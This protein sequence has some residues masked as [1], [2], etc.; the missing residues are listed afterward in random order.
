LFDIFLIES[1]HLLMIFKDRQ[2]AG[3]RLSEALVEFKNNKQTLVL[4]LPRGGVPVAFE[5]AKAL[6]LPL[7]I[8]IVRKLG[9]PGQEELAMG[10]I[11]S[12][13]GVFLNEE[14]SQHVS[15][16]AIDFEIERQ[17]RKIR[18]RL[19]L[20]GSRPLNLK[21]HSVILVDDGLATGASMMVAINTV[22]RL[23]VES[24]LVAVPV[25]PSDTVER[26]RNQVN[27]IIVL[28]TPEN[29]AGVGQW[30][31]KFTQVQDSEVVSLLRENEGAASV[32][33]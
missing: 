1:H 15:Q 14:I 3:R 12:Y 32:R 25:A 30:Y 8:L 24:I 19:E 16:A 7:G 21:N 26:L 17:K 13:G 22:K 10:A 5:V 9:F 4:G 23:G 29:F 33:F 11:D 6:N 28:E 27:K 2:D 20:Y 18:E 31:D